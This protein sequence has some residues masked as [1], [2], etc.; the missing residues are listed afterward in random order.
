MCCTFMNRECT[1][2]CTDSTLKKKMVVLE[3]KSSEPYGKLGMPRI[4]L[5]AVRSLKPEG[6]ECTEDFTDST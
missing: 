1:D 4:P 5:C 3:N 2:D 6:R